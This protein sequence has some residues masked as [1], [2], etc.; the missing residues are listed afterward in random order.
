MIEVDEKKPRGRPFKPGVCPNPGGRPKRDKALREAALCNGEELQRVLNRLIRLTKYEL[1]QLESN[2]KTQWL[3][4]VCAKAMIESGKTGDC[5]RLDFLLNR[6]IGRVQV[7]ALVEHTGK[8]GTPIQVEH[9]QT[10]AHLIADEET[11]MLL[12][13]LADKMNGPKPPDKPDT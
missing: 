5:N 11:Q 7:A 3:E 9:K 8:D 2:P 4:Q 1:V 6:L 12:E 13:R 10:I